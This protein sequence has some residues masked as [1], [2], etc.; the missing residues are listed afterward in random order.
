MLHLNIRIVGMV[1]GVY[2]RGSAKRKA[3]ELGVCGFARN[4]PDG[5]VYCEAESENQAA[6][7]EF[8]AWCKI[9]PP[10]AIVDEVRV[11]VGALANFAGFIVTH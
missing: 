6:L 3:D 10:S 7:D 2:F 5:S 4:E 11:S 1:Q 9:G 8:A